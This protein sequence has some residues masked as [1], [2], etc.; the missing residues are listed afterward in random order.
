MNYI[1]NGDSLQELKKLP[2]N[3][4]DSVVTDPPYHLTSITKRFG[5]KDAAPASTNNNDGSFARLSK[6]FMGKE[7]DGVDENGVG[8]A[9]N[10]ELWEEVLRV[11]KPGGHMLAFSGTR[12]YHRMVSAIEDAGF[13][14]RDMINYTYGSGFPKNH[15]I[16]KAI[17][18]KLGNERT[19]V[20]EGMHS[21]IHSFADADKYTGTDFKPVITK[22]NTKWE[23]FGTALK[24]SH[25]P[26]V[27][28]RKPVEGTI[29]DNVLIYG[30]GAI[31]IDGS[32]VDT[33]GEKL[34][35]GGRGKHNRGE[36]YGFQPMGDYE[37]PEGQG[38]Y[39]ANTILAA[40]EEVAALFPDNTSR[41]FQQIE[42][43]P[44][45]YQAK[46]GKKERNKGLEEFAAQSD[47]SKGNG[48]N[49]VCEFCGAPQ[50]KPEL[51]QCEVKSWVVKPTKNTHPT[52][53]PIKLME[54]LVKLIT[55]PGGVVLDPF[56]GSGTTLIA[57][58]TQGFN[59]IGI[60][61]TPE[62]VEIA[63]ARLKAY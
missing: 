58:K 30:T 9:N 46:A 34:D 53:K 39:P 42:Y 14:I 26:I 47:N 57:A 37:I 61:L 51:C 43:D 12:T 13:E 38:R 35:V 3:S 15:N 49:R 56:A 25:V 41:Y 1:I 31:N 7:W 5:K 36:G 44:I 2:D 16:G 21:N 23:G 19:V 4:I 27:L 10:V 60:E 45:I 55:P 8:I 24:P 63:E 52:V 17:D 28:A 11:L 62:Y 20:G 40:D 33:N 18:K 6:G 22:G 48:L 32:R 54:Y 29:A 59:Y 50:L